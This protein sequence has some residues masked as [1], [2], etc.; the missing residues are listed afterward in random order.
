MKELRLP[1]AYAGEARGLI[2]IKAEYIKGVQGK[3]RRKNAK[4]V[5]YY[6]IPDPWSF[7]LPGHPLRVHP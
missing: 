1:E 3:I 7:P 6:L 4:S 2:D 5:S